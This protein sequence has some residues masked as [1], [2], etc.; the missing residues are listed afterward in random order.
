MV[1][2]TEEPGAGVRRR[3]EDWPDDAR[4]HLLIRHRGLMFPR[5]PWEALVAEACDLARSAGAALVVFDTLRGLAGLDDGKEGDGSAMSRVVQV[6]SGNVGDD[7]A[8]VVVHHDRKAG[9]SHGEGASGNNA[10]VGALDAL[11][12]LR[13]RSRDDSGPERVLE[14]VG[15]WEAPDDTVVV[16]T[17]RAYELVGP[18]DESRR[19]SRE[20]RRAERMATVEQVVRDSP[21]L[22]AVEIADRAAIGPNPTRDLLKALVADG[23]IKEHGKGTRANPIRFVLAPIGGEREETNSAA[24]E[25]LPGVS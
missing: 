20:A 13:R 25:S 19:A 23:R 1:L 15:R 18:L 17:D 24:T 14:V 9:G 11:V 7:L 6:V 2:V 8:A 16:R 22:T 12:T 5:P 3:L 10:F 4:G 21:G